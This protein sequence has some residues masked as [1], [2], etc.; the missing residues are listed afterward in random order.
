MLLERFGI[1]FWLA[2]VVLASRVLLELGRGLACVGR[3]LR[4]IVRLVAR[5]IATGSA[6]PEVIL[7]VPTAARTD[8][9]PSPRS[10]EPRPAA[11]RAVPVP[12]ALL[13]SMS[14]DE[15]DRLLSTWS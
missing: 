2:V 3:G 14:H 1:V 10:G 7:L 6:R 12:A 13:E 8:D 9:S 4:N 15:M 5:F 11:P